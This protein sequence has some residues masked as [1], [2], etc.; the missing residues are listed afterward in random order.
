MTTQH[1]PGPWR[2]ET[3]RSPLTITRELDHLPAAQ[4]GHRQ[5]RDIAEVY[6]EDKGD[7]APEDY[8][9]ARLI[10]S[11]PDLLAILRRILAAHDSKNNGAVMGEAVL[12]PMFADIARAAIAKATGAPVQPSTFNLQPSAQ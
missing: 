6:V 1:T 10:A 5:F 3:N 11:A 12:C 8:A 9:N 4:G 7:G 2:A